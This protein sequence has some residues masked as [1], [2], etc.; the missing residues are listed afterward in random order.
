MKKKDRGDYSREYGVGQIR[1][2][3]G[4]SELR[5]TEP[6]VQGAGVNSLKTNFLNR[7][8]YIILNNLLKDFV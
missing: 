4:L 8:S 2:L 5:R 6:F 3:S 7:Y 1:Y